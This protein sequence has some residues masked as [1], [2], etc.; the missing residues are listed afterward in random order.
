[1]CCLSPTRVAIVAWLFC[2]CLW[3]GV[4]RAEAW[5]V[6]VDG[7]VGP[8]SA[9]HMIRGLEKA[10]EAGAELVVLR[11]DTPG[12]LDT[13][14]RMMIKSILASPV[15]VIG[16]VAPSGACAASCAP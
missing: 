4:A 11:I 1:M 15:P 16:Y 12:G 3:A 2:S 13:S 5:L 10:A 14:M 9:D 6:E 8:A 7:A